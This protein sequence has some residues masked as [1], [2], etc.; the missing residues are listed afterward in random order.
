METELQFEDRW[1]FPR[2]NWEDREYNHFETR[3]EWKASLER[4]YGNRKFPKKLALFPHFWEPDTEDQV[5]VK[6]NAAIEACQNMLKQYQSVIDQSLYHTN[7]KHEDLFRTCCYKY[8]NRLRKFHAL[9]LHLK[10]R[11]FDE[12]YKPYPICACPIGR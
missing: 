8:F 3:E 4:C 5:I 11:N 7:P 9:T 1:M 2:D 12:A 10:C 6:R